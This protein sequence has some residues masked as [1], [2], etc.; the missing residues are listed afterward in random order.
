MYACFAAETPSY[1]LYQLLR[2]DDHVWVKLRLVECRPADPHVEECQP[3]KAAS[4]AHIA[5]L[6]WLVAGSH[7]NVEG[8]ENGEDEGDSCENGAAHEEIV[9]LS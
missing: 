7:S 5:L 2:S 1:S 9:R 4:H 6:L 8:K 3:G